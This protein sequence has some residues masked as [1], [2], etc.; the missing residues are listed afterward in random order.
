MGLSIS[1]QLVAMMGGEI[2]VKSTLGEGSAFGFTAKFGVREAAGD[3]EKIDLRSLRILVVD[4][5]VT[6]LR[7]LNDL[8]TNWG[9]KVTA[10]RDAN[11][12]L[13]VMRRA[14]DEGTPFPLLLLDAEMPELSG[15]ALAEKMREE[16]GLAA[17]VIM[18]LGSAGDMGD[19]ARCRALGI[20]S[21]VAKPVYQAELKT[22]ILPSTEDINEPMGA[23]NYKPLKDPRSF[24]PLDVLL[25]EDN[26]VNRRLAV[27]LLEKQGHTVITANNG[28]EALEVLERL[29]WTVDLIL[30]DVQMPEMDGY[31]ATAAIRER[32][33]RTGSHLPI[34]AMTAHALDRDR[35][36]CLGA[37]MDG[38]LSKPIRIETFFET[39]ERL[40][41]GMAVSEA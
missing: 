20:D 28:R 30:M 14:K 36:R 31:Q 38:Y 25:V 5:N 40:A 27:R 17:R 29:Q 22:A 26:P 41:A 12:A 2:Y 32:E 24:P 21:H 34:I 1:S 16:P 13:T 10:V 4:D 6:S 33:K 35:E 19:A 18:M 11:T 39:I 37:G 15:F 8:L 23:A 3:V 7:V 9:A